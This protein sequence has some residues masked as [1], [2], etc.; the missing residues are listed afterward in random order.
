ML[1]L[2]C[3]VTGMFFFFKFWLF[4]FLIEKVLTFLQ[5]LLLFLDKLN[6]SLLILTTCEP[7][8]VV[9]GRFCKNPE[10]QDDGSC[11]EVTKSF[12]RYMTTL[13]NV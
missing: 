7:L 6:F 2:Y 13:F 10:I 3:I 9:Y 1:P 12:L 4:L 8:L 11:S 5:S